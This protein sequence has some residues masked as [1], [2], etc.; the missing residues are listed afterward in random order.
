MVVVW[1]I[2]AITTDYGA[3]DLTGAGAKKTG[4]RWN[5]PG[6]SVLYCASTRALAALETVV[7]L[8]AEALPLN[9]YLVQIEIPKKIFA[10]RETLTAT[11]SPVGWDALPAGV[12]SLNFGDE[13]LKSKRSAVI[14]VPSIVVP[15]ESNILINPEH[16]DAAVI[17]AT[18]VRKWIY[19]TRIT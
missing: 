3:D 2:A 14:A 18:V 17:T 15:E 16:T 19:D 8:A 7:H 9:R 12:I 11:A 6:L 1:R 13:W 10:A 4:G 5:R